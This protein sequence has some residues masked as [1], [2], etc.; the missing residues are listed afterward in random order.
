[1]IKILTLTLCI[2]Y[3]GSIVANANK[4]EQSSESHSAATQQSSNKEKQR[5]FL[6][7][8]GI[9]FNQE[10]YQGYNKRIIPIPF[11]GYQGEKLK[12][13]GPFISY[14]IASSDN[15]TIAVIVA[16]TFK[17]F[18]ESDSDVFIGMKKRS[19]SVAAGIGLRYNWHNWKA[20]IANTHDI[21]SKSNGHIITVS[22]ARTFN[23]GPIFIEPSLTLTYQASNYVDYYYGVKQQ[24]QLASRVAYTGQS[25]LNTSLGLSISTPIFFNGFT[26]LSTQYTRYDSSITNSPLVDEEAGLSVT[27]LFSRF[28]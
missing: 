7:G 17:G 21:L 6:Y 11:I 13:L 14:D 5:G 1:M 9:A 3:S 15:A 23:K 22:L 18:D 26:R 2:F 20:N 27:L 16:P 10:I 12:V 25:A 28:F 24:E 19:S 4:P 8:M